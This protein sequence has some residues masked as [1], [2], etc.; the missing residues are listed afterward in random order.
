M[1]L[2]GNMKKRKLDDFG[3]SDEVYQKLSRAGSFRVRG[4]DLQRTT[5]TSG[6]EGFRMQQAEPMKVIK[7]MLS[8]RLSKRANAH[9]V[10]LWQKNEAEY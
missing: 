2:M 5:K 6:S 3:K 1:F 9:E 10:L 8:K 7:T 4:G